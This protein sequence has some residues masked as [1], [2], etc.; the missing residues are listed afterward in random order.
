VPEGDGSHADRWLRRVTAG[1]VLLL[2][3]L[4][5][6]A[7]LFDLGPRWF[8]LR[9]PSPVTQ[10]ARVAPPPGL[11]LPD[12]RPP[13][14]VAPGTPARRADPAALRAA[15]ASAM[16]DRALGRHFAVEVS[17]LSDGRVVYR[18]GAD[19]VTPA[20]TMKLL[21]TTAAL[22]VLGPEHRFT[23][24]TVASRHGR[25]VTLV[26]GGDPLLERVPQIYEGTYPSD[27]SRGTYPERADLQTLA[28]A[29]ARALNGLGRTKV[30][31]RYDASLFSGPGA[32]P[33]WRPNYLSDN[34]VSRISPLWVDEGRVQPGLE[35]RSQ[36]PAADAA[37]AFAAALERR[38]IKVVGA[39][40][41]AVAP[42][43]ATGLA[44]V[45]SA[46]LAQ[47]VQHIL[48]V[49]DNEGAEVL[50]RQTALAVGQPASFTGGV[51]AVTSVLRKLGVDLDGARIYDGS[52]LSRQDRV[53]PETMLDVLR[54]A[55][56]PKRP[57]L[58]PVLTGLP[59]AGFTGSLSYR[60]DTRGQ[61][62]LGWVRAK[63][64]TLSHVNAYAG[65]V[66]SRDGV[67]M[68]FVVVADRVREPDTLEARADLDQIAGALAG[69]TCAATP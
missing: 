27:V 6:L 22:S 54:V 63:T 39:P 32:S 43:G 24:R 51:R 50:A 35:A 5:V 55:A 31:L 65:T 67:V 56:D 16:R 47:I 42:R 53:R 44:S 9:Y 37:Q 58:R 4:A 18:H 14:A 36:D 21:T 10:P 57:G 49:S 64:G 62:G 26:G 46:P 68:G 2:L 38:K 41:A 28:R 60:F 45:R 52:G 3:L 34:V 1:L 69:C 13:A 59:V 30:R 20:S 7:Y 48:E 29:T 17:Q 11:S 19:L 25:V 12:A 61:A 66:T 40:V 15:L 8:G 23:T 33:R